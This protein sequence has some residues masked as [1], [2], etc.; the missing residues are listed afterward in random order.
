MTVVTL[1]FW[2]FIIVGGAAL[3]IEVI[4]YLRKI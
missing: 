4:D 2:C 3:V 1:L